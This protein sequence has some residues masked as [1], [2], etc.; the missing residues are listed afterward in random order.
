MKDYILHILRYFALF[1]HPLTPSELH[2]FL[3][4][5][6]TFEQ[7]QMEIEVLREEGEIVFHNGYLQRSKDENF[8]VLR[9][10]KEKRALEMIEGSSIY[11]RIISKFPFVRSV[12]ISGSL[13]K[14]SAGPNA[15]LDF[16]I[17]TAKD[18]LWTCRTLLHLFKKLTFITGH[19]NF[20]CMNYFVDEAHLSLPFESFYTA[21]EL[22]TLIP[23]YGKTIYN[24]LKIENNWTSQYLPNHTGEPLVKANEVITK[25]WIKG[26]IEMVLNLVFPKL[27]NHWL[28]HLTDWKWRR[29][30]SSLK[31]SEEEY[32]QAMLTRVDI[33]KNHPHNFEKKVLEAMSDSDS[34]NQNVYV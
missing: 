6:A 5:A 31:L 21:L 14:L 2:L 7:L 19:Q 13:S 18:R 25:S 10:Q 27:I 20:F 3:N 17:V 23:V 1:K 8:S 4:T 32:D 28:M 29:K 16:F 26:F 11:T 12:L 22:Q 30:F 24:R 9:D 15:D 33:S 34:V